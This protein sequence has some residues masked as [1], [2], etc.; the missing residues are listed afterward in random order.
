MTEPLPV[1]PTVASVML[2]VYDTAAQLERF[3]VTDPV[4]VAAEMHMRAL[5]KCLDEQH[6]EAKSMASLATKHRGRK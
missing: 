3:N 1:K 5:S 6:C 4:D 2:L